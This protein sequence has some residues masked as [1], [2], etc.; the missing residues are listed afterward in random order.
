M[1]SVEYFS[2]ANNPGENLLDNCGS[3]TVSYIAPEILRKDG[4]S[5]SVDMW[6][7]GVLFHY[8]VCGISAV[9]FLLRIVTNKHSSMTSKMAWQVP[10]IPVPSS[11]GVTSHA[12]KRSSR[13][14]Y[15]DVGA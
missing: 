1:D 9:F 8:I 4:Y 2:L 12:N 3:G 11:H 15:V 5:S 7:A 10:S 6:S 13:F 14:D